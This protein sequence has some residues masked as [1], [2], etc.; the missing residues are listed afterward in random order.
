MIRFEQMGRRLDG[1]ILYKLQI[2]GKTER[3]GMTL[4][5]VIVEIQREDEEDLGAQRMPG[6]TR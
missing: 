4:E 1:E 6:R 5:E 2:D 3:E